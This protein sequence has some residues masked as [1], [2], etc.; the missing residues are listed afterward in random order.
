MDPFPAGQVLVQKLHHT[1]GVMLIEFKKVEN[2]LRQF[3]HG[4]LHQHDDSDPEQIQLYLR[5]ILEDQQYSTKVMIRSIAWF[6]WKHDKQQHF[7]I[8]NFDRSLPVRHHIFECLSRTSLYLESMVRELEHLTN[9]VRY[10]PCLTEPKS[11]LQSLFWTKELV[12]SGHLSVQLYLQV[13]QATSPMTLLKQPPSARPRQD[14]GYDTV[15]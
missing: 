11:F 8:R 3:Y 1:F 2:Q 13:S 15:G 6:Y 7:R 9:L 4:P 14:Q 12:Q 5:S 10:P